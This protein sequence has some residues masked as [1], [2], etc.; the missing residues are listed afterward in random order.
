MKRYSKL[1][2]A[3]MLVL[4][5]SLASF[6]QELDRKETLVVTGAAWGPPSSWNILIPN[7]AEGTTALVYETLFSF[8][9][10]KNEYRPWLA[11]SGEWVSDNVYVL[12]L[13]KGIKW[14]DGKNFTAKDVVFTWEMIMKAPQVVSRDGFDDIQRMETPDD[15]TV[16]MYL[17]EQRAAWLLNWA[18][19]SL[20]STAWPNSWA[21]R[22]SPSCRRS[23]SSGARAS[24]LMPVARG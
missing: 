21:C 10:L 19:M 22:A 7:P 9:P 3:I 4:V 18:A 20:G 2:L 13:R 1:C 24:S 23:R 8:N 6:A 12:K 5:F 16:V 14:N 17:K 11:E 15:Y